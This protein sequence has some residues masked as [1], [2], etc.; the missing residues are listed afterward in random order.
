MMMLPLVRALT[1]RL[2]ADCA[3]LDTGNAPILEKVT[4][5]TVDLLRWWFQQDCCDGRTVNFHSGQRQAILHAIYAHE[6][7]QP[8]TL[9]DLYQ[10]LAAEDLLT[11][12]RLEEVVQSR[13]PKYCLKMATGT[14]KTWVLQALLYWQMLNAA[15][16][17][18]D[19]RFTRN[20]LLVAPGLI[21]RKSTRLNS[22]H[23]GISYAVFCLK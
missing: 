5:V 8:E 21:D 16:A 14:G 13:H 1:P 11:A 3:G 17:R 22:S 18:E 23:L 6:I 4:P 2:Q 12:R 20:F 10:K 15:R 7:L 19:K 9:V